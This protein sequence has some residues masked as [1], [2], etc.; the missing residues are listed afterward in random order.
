MAASQV[1]QEV[2][3]APQEVEMWVGYDRQ[4][5]IEWV[6]YYLSHSIRDFHMAQF[7]LQ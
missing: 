3:P 6:L 1:G 4:A 2:G 7:P 5:G